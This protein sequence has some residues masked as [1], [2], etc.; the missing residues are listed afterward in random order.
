MRARG[1]RFAVLS[2][3]LFTSASACTGEFD[4]SRQTP[5]R[6]SL[7]QEMFTMV[8]DRVGAQAL[9]EDVLGLSYHA[10]CHA[11]AQGG[12]ASTVDVAKL[13]PLGE[14]LDTKGKP[15]PLERQ[16]KNRDHR[17]ARI[18]ALAR[19]RVDL[20]EAFDAA[21]TNEMIGAK[22]LDNPDDAKSCD[23]KP[24]VR[25]ENDLRTELSD[26][27]GRFTDL[28]NDDTLPHV[29]RA[30]ARLM[31]GIEKDPEAQT[32]LARFDARRGYRPAEISMGVARP[33][34][35]YPRIVEL[36]NAL[37]RIL[38]SDLDP[39]GL[40]TPERPPVKASQRT[41][42]DR[43]RGPAN[44][45]L[46]D[47]LSILREELRTAKTL[48]ELEP[49]ATSPDPRDPNLV[50]LSRPR[51]NLEMARTIF[52]AE[53]PAFSIGE[54]KLTVR[55]DARGL[56]KVA[57]EGGKVPAPFVDLTGPGGKPDGL[58]DVDALGQFVSA[59]P[60]LPLPFREL[61]AAEAASPS[62]SRDAQGRAL[63]D[64]K[65][66]FEYIDVSST[67]MAALTRDLVPLLDPDV[68]RKHETVMDLLAGLPVVVGRRQ[69]GKDSLATYDGNVSKAFRGYREDDAPLLDL[70]HAVGQVLADPTTDDTLALVQTLA[71]DKPQVLARLIGMGLR[72]KEIADRHPEAKIPG[73]STLW[74]E[75]LDV[76]VRIVERPKLVEDIIRAFG[77]DRTLAMS[78]SSA[79]YMKFRDQISYDRGNLNGPVFN[80]TTNRVEDMKTPVDRSKPDSGFN[81]SAFQRFLRVLHETNGMSVCTKQGAVAHIVWNGIGLDFPSFA[82]Q[83]ACFTLG[84]D[85]PKNPSPVCGLFRVEN[86]ASEIVNAV[87]GKV[88]L[89]IRDDCLRKL[90]ASPLT[91]IVGGA[92]A[93]LE[94]VSGIKGFNTKPTPQGIFRLV[95]FDLPHDGLPG[96]T[97]N[98][99]TTNFLKDIFDPP[100]TLAC[101]PF[102][103][104]DTDGKALNLRKC[105]TFADS[106]RGRDL[107]ALFPLEQMGFLEAAKPLAKAFNDSD[108]NLLFV[109]L[110]DTL[111]KHWGTAGQTKSECDPSLPKSDARW[112]S[113]DGAVSYEALVGEALETDLFPAMHD[114]VREL[115]AIKIPH[116]DTRDAKGTCTKVTE[117]DGV[118]VLAE[119]L[120]AM[121]DPA[122]SRANGVKQR[123]GDAGVTRNDGSRNT[124]V[125]PIYLLIDALKGFD[126]RLD[127]HKAANP[128]DDRLPQWRRARSQLV[129]QLFAVEGSG[130]S[131][132]FA[133]KSVEKIL[134][135]LVGSLRSQIAANCP[136]P[137][138]DCAWGRVDLPKKV[139]NVVTGPTFATVLDL[140]DVIRADEGARTELERL[141]VFLLESAQ[142]DASKTTLTSL[143]DVLQM[144]E[145]D[146]NLTALLHAI[147]DVAGP[148]VVGGDGRVASRGL[149]LAAVEALSRILGEARLPNGTRACR[150]E[151]DPNRTLAVVMRRLVTPRDGKPAPIHVL[152]DVAADVNRRR[153][154]QTTKLEPDDYASIAHEIA[155]FCINESKGL[156]QVYEVLKQATK[157]L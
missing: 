51:G 11:D 91:G 53:D 63:R 7:G 137:A 139:T 119:A 81:Q 69:E 102:P 83:A 115:A 61:G 99:K 97:R 77:D 2:L 10:V 148:E 135:T 5:K 136:D 41:A 37:L 20:V 128:G 151:I 43:I 130:A 74:D 13:P 106:V 85:P 117:Y 21:L 1:C 4:T 71:R 116:C 24:G 29:T 73:G 40:T 38:S 92:D 25:S 155:D 65:P 111:H 96:D 110:F 145:D 103:F 12:F 62:I 127:E 35:S 143:V 47:M 126:R 156:E 36:A 18:E 3:A 149:L 46:V 67:F 84:A 31:E 144:F 86:I 22:D 89:D 124:Q 16:Q 33:A 56:A 141:L 68:S 140:L 17:I 88:N 150:R 90:V 152:M 93:F 109:D 54:P 142:A 26:A 100:P 95:Y 82:A 118:K 27:L 6:G 30:L 146:A 80:V 112:C 101:P 52:L 32:A 114:G 154:E 129:D 123:S 131:T 50:R 108:G 138:K 98:P 64:G 28:Y 48:P 122:K 153:P 76:L 8:C 45:A 147:A 34:L 70:V 94:D 72:I 44:A 87:L 42:N 105:A 75:M 78:R 134:P 107:D 19:R 55:R 9:R 39:L 57:L 58:A 14:A 59:G 60:L 49:L 121:V 66:A 15:V 79:A 113:Q 120:K 132:R 125:T 133:N 104:T 23:P 157:D